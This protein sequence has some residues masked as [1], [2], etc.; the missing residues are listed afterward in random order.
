ML[1]AP[2]LVAAGQEGTIDNCCGL[3][4]VSVAC[5]P[6]AVSSH[7]RGCFGG[8]VVLRLESCEGGIYPGGNRGWA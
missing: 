8:A 1:R 3:W 4:A 6:H 5:S 7:P 2:S